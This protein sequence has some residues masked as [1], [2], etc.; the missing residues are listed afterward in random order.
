MNVRRY[1]PPYAG[2]IHAR[3][4][5]EKAYDTDCPSGVMI[6]KS[7]EQWKQELGIRPPRDFCFSSFSYIRTTLLNPDTASRV[8]REV[9]E[10]R[11]ARNPALIRVP[12]G[13]TVTVAGTAL[14]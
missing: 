4:A 5:M 1:V 3:L 13:L 8:L 9:R 10:V 14:M 7:P 12:N 2:R 6:R 11:I